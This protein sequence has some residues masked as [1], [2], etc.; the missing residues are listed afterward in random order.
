M[1]VGTILDSILPYLWMQSI[2][3]RCRLQTLPAQLADIG[4][5]DQ[6][7]VDFS[8][9]LIRSMQERYA[10]LE[11]L[12]WAVMD[13]RDMKTFSDGRFDVAIDKVRSVYMFIAKL[14]VD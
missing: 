8:P 3:L 5:Q 9:V 10:H 7:C 14:L 2:D 11:G 4:Y 1:C 6:T 12:Q 13:V